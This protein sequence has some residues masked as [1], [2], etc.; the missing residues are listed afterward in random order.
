LAAGG[1]ADGR[2]LAAA[3]ML[4]AHGA[5]IGTRF[6]ATHEALGSDKAKQRIASANG[7]ETQRTRVFD[8]VRRLSWPAAITGRALRNRF[9]DRWHD[10]DAA[11][12]DAL[13]VEG[14]AFQDAVREEDFD[15]A[16]VWAGEA[17][18]LIGAVDSAA[19]LVSRIGDEA[20]ACLSR[21]IDLMPGRAA[22]P[23]PE[24]RRGRR[25][26]GGAT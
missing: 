16:M 6:Y 3:L 19:G 17:V 24:A 7:D 8:I 13:S 20:R 25:L 26:S 12:A 5:L 23:R 11:L 18:D 22:P 21:G 1:I 2:G 15:H 9:M 14:P 10:R 4:G